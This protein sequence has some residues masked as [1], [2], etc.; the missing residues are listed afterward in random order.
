MNS[1]P[2]IYH[3]VLDGYSNNHGLNTFYAFDNSKFTKNL[4]GLGFNIYSDAT[5]PYNQTLPIISSIFNMEYSITD[6]TSNRFLPPKSI[7]SAWG[8]SPYGGIVADL[9]KSNGYNFTFTPS[10]YGFLKFPDNIS[11]SK[12]DLKSHITKNY[13]ITEYL[14]SLWWYKN[15]HTPNNKELYKTTIEAFL[16]H[17]YIKSKKPIFYY[18]HIL[19]PHPPFDIDIKGDFTQKYSNFSSIN[20]GSHST[21]MDKDLI[22]EYK[23]G[24]VEKIKFSNEYI[25]NK[26]NNII[27]NDSNNKIIIVQGDHG[28][29]SEY[30]QESLESSCLQ[31]R[32]KPLLAIYSDYK[33]ESS[34]ENYTLVNIYRDIFT[35]LSNQNFEKLETKTYYLPWGL[36]EKITP[37]NI[38]TQGTCPYK[39]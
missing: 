4:K 25:I 22:K 17:S 21:K 9:L 27:N 13:F 36:P 28:G 33:L 26:V 35:V 2:N 24:Y 11:T 37:I 32:Y 34:E 8:A 31:E 19:S 6:A 30:S 20:D 14:N 39:T 10:G 29:G 38:V 5:S 7:M 1:K 12:K 15:L 3:I 18:S 23:S 16:D